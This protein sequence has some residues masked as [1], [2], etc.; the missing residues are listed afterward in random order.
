MKRK[1]VTRSDPREAG[2]GGTFGTGPSVFLGDTERL[3]GVESGG[4]D[5]GLDLGSQGPALMGAEGPGT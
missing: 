4:L 2:A 3:R 1:P 5:G